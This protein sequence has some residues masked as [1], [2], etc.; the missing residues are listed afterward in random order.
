MSPPSEFLVGVIEGFYGR[1]WPVETRLAYAGYLASAGLNTYL[2]CPKEDAYL[3]KQWWD[4]WP[5]QQWQHLLE[6]S[7][8]YRGH[9]INW[10]VGLSPFALY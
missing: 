10:G 4:H 1:P 3:R 8:V 9:G 2:Y 6:L 7:A 5:E